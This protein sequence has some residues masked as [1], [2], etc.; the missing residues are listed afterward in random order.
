MSNFLDMISNL[1]DNAKL[2]NVNDNCNVITDKLDFTKK[3]DLD[4]LKD[5]VAKLKDDNNPIVGMIK[6][7][8]GN[9]YEST[10]DKIVSDAQKI[11]DD[12]HKGCK[13]TNKTVSSTDTTR[14]SNK[15]SDEMKLHFSKLVVE[16]M[17]QLIFPNYKNMTF[18]QAESI[19]N[20]LHEFA[21]WIY[22][23]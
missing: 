11:Y 20:A 18:E 9:E 19:H 10:L 22:S 3:A 17:N 14:P 8:S 13:T 2:Y 1:T 16:Y 23:K 15:V 12:S 6:I 7:L 4:K 21:C 5:S